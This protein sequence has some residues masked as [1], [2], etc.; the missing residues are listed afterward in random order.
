MCSLAAA[1]PSPL[2]AGA[3]ALEVLAHGLTM[4][5][6]EDPDALPPAESG[7]QLAGLFRFRNSLDAELVRRTAALDRSRAYAASGAHSAGAWL[8]REARLS[9]SAA[10]EQ[11]RVARQLERL[12]EATRAFGAGEVGFQHCAAITRVTEEAP[13]GVVAE[14]EP[15]LVEAA[16]QTD[17]YRLAKLTRHLRHTFDADACLADFE[18]RQAR[19]KVHLSESMD[20]LFFLDGVLDAETGAGLRTALEAIMGPRSGCDERTPAQRRHDALGDLVRRQL[21]GGELPR[22]GGQR[23]HLTLTADVATL[24][25]LPGSRAAD[26]DWGQPVPAETLRRIACDCAVTPVLVSESGE[27]LSVGRT[28]RTFTGSQRRALVVRDKG[29]VLCGRPATWTDAHHLRHW[30]DGGETAVRNGVLVC[31]RCHYRLHEGGYQLVRKPDGTWTVVPQQR[32]P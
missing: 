6:A 17:P 7:L 2:E 28:R 22:R 10:F 11:V 16:R 5:R 26:L 21:D 14:A 3:S 8:E 25:R 23:P 1:P 31:R 15:A 30:V 24:A 27:P 20:G 18:R 29:C 9:P 12:P 32:P 13:G 19:R 4:L